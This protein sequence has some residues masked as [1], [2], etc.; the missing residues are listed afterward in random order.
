MAKWEISSIK[1]NS[2]AEY[3]PGKETQLVQDSAINFLHDRQWVCFDFSE[4]LYKWL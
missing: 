1:L 3:D 2:I 4:L